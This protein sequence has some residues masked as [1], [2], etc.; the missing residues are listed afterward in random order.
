MLITA[1]ANPVAAYVEA[2][3]QASRWLDAHPGLEQRRLTIRAGR[4]A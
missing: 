2:Q 3:A 1:G 4:A